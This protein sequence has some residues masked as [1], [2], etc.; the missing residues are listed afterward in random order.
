[1]A[2]VPVGGGRARAGLEIDHSEPQARVWRSRGRAAAHRRIEQSQ[3]ARHVL[4]SHGGL[5]V[6]CRAK[7]VGMEVAVPVVMVARSEGAR[8]LQGLAGLRGDAPSE[9]RGVDGER[10]G[11]PRAARRSG[12]MRDRAPAAG[13]CAGPYA[14]VL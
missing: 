11:R 9:A 2:A 8:G 6:V 1:M 3:R 5:A 12:G 13:Y 14:C 4:A 7:L 10:A